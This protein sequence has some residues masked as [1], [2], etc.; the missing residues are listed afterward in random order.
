MA[1]N[2]ILTW[3]I[4]SPKTIGQDLP[5]NQANS[6]TVKLTKAILESA[7]VDLQINLLKEQN[8][9]STEVIIGISVG[10]G[11]IILIII[12]VVLKCQQKI[13]PTQRKKELLNYT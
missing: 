3:Q 13:F 11:V 7:L 1:E 10:A 4:A 2:D 6:G 9:L 12:G 5:I 8:G